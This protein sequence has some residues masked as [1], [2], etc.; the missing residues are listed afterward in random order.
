MNSKAVYGLYYDMSEE[1]GG[2]LPRGAAFMH[3]S[4]KERDTDR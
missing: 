4:E 1:F 2:Q 3:G